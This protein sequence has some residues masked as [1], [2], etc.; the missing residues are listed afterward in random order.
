MDNKTIKKSGKQPL[1]LIKPDDGKQVHMIV[2]GCK[3]KLN[4][5]ATPEDSAVNDIKRM[6]LGGVTKP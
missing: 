2:D 5:P 4:F 3:I 6:M 1:E